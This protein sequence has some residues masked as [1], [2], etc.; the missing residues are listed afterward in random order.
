[1]RVDFWVAKITGIFH[2]LGA[3]LFAAI[4]VDIML[5][6]ASRFL[7][8]GI[9]GLDEVG[10]I[11][12]V[13]IVFTGIAY[14]LREEKH[15]QIDILTNLL[16]TRNRAISEGFSNVAMIIICG[17]MIWQGFRLAIFAYV[18]QFQSLL[19]GFPLYIMRIGVLVGMMLFLAEVFCHMAA[20]NVKRKKTL[21]EEV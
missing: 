11:L 8:L 19:F 21:I 20:H 14:V 10:A 6:I 2:I 7:R 4:V 13:L 16:N 1:M 9:V 5:G 18:R 3:V 17:V 12:G 15:V